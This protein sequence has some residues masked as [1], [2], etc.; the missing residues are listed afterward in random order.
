MVVTRLTLAVRSVELFVLR[1]K[2][3][4][5]FK[6]AELQVERGIANGNPVYVSLLDQAETL[7]GKFIERW[8]GTYA[9]MF[10]ALSDLETLATP[11]EPV[12]AKPIAGMIVLIVAFLLSLAAGVGAFGAIVHWSYHLLTRAH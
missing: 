9:N 6:Q 3:A 10:P 8:P 11:P 7:I 1:Y 12:K 5:V 2:L 4:Q